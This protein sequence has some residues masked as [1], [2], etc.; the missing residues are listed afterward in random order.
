MSDQV[1]TVSKA[2]RVP[3]A[4]Q[5][6]WCANVWP[7]AKTCREH[8][9]GDPSYYWPES[10]LWCPTEK[11]AYKLPR[12][13]K[14]GGGMNKLFRGVQLQSG[15]AALTCTNCGALFV[16]WECPCGGLHE[17]N[18]TTAMHA[19]GSGG[20]GC[21]IAALVVLGLLILWSLLA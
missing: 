5:K 7:I 1:W 11:A 13:A 20:G 14:C 10:A 21:C 16:A 15:G 9:S 19:P 17:T 18:V 2:L 12:C 8:R 3:E 6:K 4:E